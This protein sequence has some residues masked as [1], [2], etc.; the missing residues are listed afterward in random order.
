ML[1]PVQTPKYTFNT[2]ACVNAR[3]NP[4][5]SQQQKIYRSSD[6]GIVT[7]TNFEPRQQKSSFQKNFVDGE[8][9][10]GAHIHDKPSL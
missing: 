3:S 9:G 4:L 10:G 6:N 7:L 8:G 2:L 5:Q 1:Y